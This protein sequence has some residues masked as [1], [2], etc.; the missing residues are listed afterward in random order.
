MKNFNIKKIVILLSIFHFLF[1][2]V[3]LAQ[4]ASSTNFISNNSALVIVGGESSSTNFVNIGVGGL[5]A[6]GETS[7]TNFV[8][9]GGILYFGNL[10]TGSSGGGGSGGGSNGSSGSSI[11]GAGGGGGAVTIISSTNN[12]GSSTSSF[13]QQAASVGLVG[14]IA[15]LFA[16][17]APLLGK[18]ANLFKLQLSTNNLGLGE[19]PLAIKN[20]W[21]LLGRKGLQDLVFQS[22]PSEFSMFKEKFPQLRTILSQI[23]INRLPQLISLQNVNLYLPGFLEM[24]RQVP[25][26]I[27]FARSP[28]NKID[29]NINLKLDE[30]GRPQQT[31]SVLTGQVISLAVKPKAPARSV[32]GL[33]IF[34]NSVAD[35]SFYTGLLLTIFKPLKFDGRPS[36]LA[37]LTQ[38]SSPERKKLLTLNQFE[39]KD[40]D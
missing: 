16:L 12:A 27:V 7:S 19:L 24:R 17:R 9:Q 32:R 28:D 38:D 1:S 11:S 4:Q 23:G 10:S 22:L 26:E 21:G 13:Y 8:N 37:S 39:Y 18:V 35:N 36:L 25:T 15:N 33:V 5:I 14:K 2:E 34:K 3:A 29:Y 20:G 40:P 6:P 31:I 30:N